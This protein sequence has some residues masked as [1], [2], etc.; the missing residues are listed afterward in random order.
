MLPAPA[1]ERLAALAGVVG[2]LAQNRNRASILQYAFRVAFVL[3]TEFVVTDEL[4]T[5]VVSKPEN[6]APPPIA[7]LSFLLC[8]QS[9]RLQ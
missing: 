4:I 8:N 5:L 3:V 2:G 9:L 6:V 7:L 1:G